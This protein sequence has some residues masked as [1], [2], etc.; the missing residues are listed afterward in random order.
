MSHIVDSGID[1]TVTTRNR[2]IDLVDISFNKKWI[3]SNNWLETESAL[4]VFLY[5]RTLPKWKI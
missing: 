1:V 4:Y 3:S 2:I 5:G